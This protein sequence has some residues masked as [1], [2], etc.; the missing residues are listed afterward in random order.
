M[1]RHAQNPGSRL[2]S[3]LRSAAG[4]IFFLCGVF[5]WVFKLKGSSGDDGGLLAFSPMQVLLPTLGVASVSI[6]LLAGRGRLALPMVRGGPTL[7]FC[8][9]AG[10]ICLGAVPHLAHASYGREAAFFIV[11]WMMPFM[12]FY[13]FLLARRLGVSWRPLLYG[14]ALGALLSV[15]A[16]EL[17]RYGLSIPVRRQDDGRF[18]GFLNHPNQYGIVVSATAP[19]IVFFLRSRGLWEKLLGLTMIP[20]YLL[21]LFESLSK[22]NIIL[23][24]LSIT[25]SALLLT[26]RT[27]RKLAAIAVAVL[28]FAGG[29]IAAGTVGLEVMYE[30]APRNAKYFEDAFLSTSDSRAIISREEIWE[31]AIDHIRDHPALG[32][33][34]GR[35]HDVLIN[36]HAHNLFLQMWLDAGVAGELGVLLV[37][38]G[39]FWGAG[40]VIRPALRL[41]G[42]PTDEQVMRILSGIAIVD[43][44]IANSLSDSF[45]TATMPVFVVFAAFAFCRDQERRQPVPDAA[46]EPAGREGGSPFPVSPG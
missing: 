12:Y 34:P 46:P 36:N 35:T 28:V 44:V 17:T 4:L 45:G 13:F 30:L 21:C 25:A 7:T 19:L 15:I 38:V 8:L 42:T 6:L 11:R 10:L 33:G 31:D 29:M 14:I 9:G 37:V 2:T 43:Y 39:V 32:L 18:G 3:L 27:P 40:R 24:F 16:V 20:L 22:A 26:A 41:G 5:I 1:S 23:F